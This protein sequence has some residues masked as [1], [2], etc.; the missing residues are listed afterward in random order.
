MLAQT[1]APADDVLT[2]ANY[3][4][5]TGKERGAFFVSDT[6]LSPL[7]YA[8]A[9]GGGGI[10]QLNNAPP[11]WG[12]GVEG[13]AKRSGSVL[14]IVLL[15]GAITQ[16]L[17]APLGYEPR[18]VHCGCTGFMKRTSHA[19]VWSIITKNNAG[20]NRLNLPALAGAYGSGMLATLA[21]YPAR[22]DPLK[23]GVRLGT[24]QLPF[25]PGANWLREFSPEIRRTLHLH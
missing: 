16:G 14:G 10:Q 8:A 12:Q 3:K 19:V 9:V 17:A 4:P 24:L 2:S 23:D 15:Q 13:F 1:P 22:F 20:A 6:L 7:T 25:L 5:L 18:Y 21:W 11:E